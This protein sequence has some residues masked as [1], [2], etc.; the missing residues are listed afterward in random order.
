MKVWVSS[1]SGC[2]GLPDTVGLFDLDASTSVFED[3]SPSWSGAAGSG[4]ISHT[5]ASPPTLTPGTNYMAVAGRLTSNGTKYYAITAGSVPSRSSGPLSSPSN[6]FYWD[7]SGTYEI[8]PNA[9][10]N[11]STWVDVEVDTGDHGSA[12]FLLKKLVIAGNSTE[13]SIASGGL[14][15]KKLRISGTSNETAGG[16]AVVT[17]K[18][19]KISGTSHE[20]SSGSAHLL[21]KK[22]KISGISHEATHGSG[23]I[24]L[25]K[26]HIRALGDQ[27]NRASQLFVFAAI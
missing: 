27:K 5:P 6:P 16:V 20:T 10:G 23:H 12:A 1:P 3:T 17:L 22:L 13:T 9:F 11:F 15:L 4:W 8:P 24:T 21:L 25:K 14:L 7:E 26:I 18:K 19:I 2:T